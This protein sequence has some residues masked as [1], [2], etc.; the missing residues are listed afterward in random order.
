[1][2]TL[3]EELPAMIAALEAKNPNSRFAKDLKEQLRASKATL[4]QTAQQV[5]RMQAAPFPKQNAAPQET[6]GPTT[7]AVE[8]AVQRINE[9]HHGT[10][11]Q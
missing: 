4:G 8:A 1:M 9:H 5:Y 3:I 11:K 2:S 6:D 10:A 7:A